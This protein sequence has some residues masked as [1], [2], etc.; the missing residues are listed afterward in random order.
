MCLVFF[1]Y[2]EMLIKYLS[3]GLLTFGTNFLC[4]TMVLTGVPMGC[5]FGYIV[6]QKSALTGFCASDITLRVCDDRCG[7]QTSVGDVVEALE[8]IRL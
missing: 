8:A 5:T 6:S 3:R 2:I 4:T 1:D 7:E